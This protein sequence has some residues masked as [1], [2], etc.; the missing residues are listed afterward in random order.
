MKNAVKEM[1]ELELEELT[2]AAGGNII[3]DIACAFGEHD[4]KFVHGFTPDYEDG[5]QI[6]YDKYVCRNCGK[7]FYYKYDFATGKKTRIY[8]EEFEAHSW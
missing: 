2:K 6:D 4:L 7:V 1:K 3:D 8:H 5:H